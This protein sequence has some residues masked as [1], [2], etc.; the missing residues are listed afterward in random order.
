MM[1]HDYVKLRRFH[2]YV[3]VRSPRQ[4]E[5]WLQ[6]GFVR[7]PDARMFAAIAQAFDPFAPRAFY[8]EVWRRLLPHRPLPPSWFANDVMLELSRAA[9]GPVPSLYVLERRIERG[10]LHESP[11]FEAPPL[12]PR[13]ATDH[14]LVVEAV[15]DTELPAPVAGLRLELLIADGEIKSAQTDANG[16]ARVERVQAGR[17]VIRVLDLDGALWQPVEGD[18]SQP[19]SSGHRPRVHVVKQGECLSRIAHLYG[20]ASW[21]KLWNAAEN[22]QLRKRRKSPHVLYP[23]D[24]VTV[25]GVDV[26]EIIRP[27]DATHRLAIAVPPYHLAVILRDFNGLPFTHEPYELWVTGEAAPRVGETDDDGLVRATLPARASH[28][29]VR[30]NRLGMRWLFAVGALDPLDGGEVVV[31]EGEAPV[32]PENS[33]ISGLQARLHALG[34]PAGAATGQ[35]NEQTER[36]LLA[37][38]T[39]ELGAP[40]TKAGTWTSDCDDALTAR[41]GA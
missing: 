30:C 35:W 37:F 1:G 27:T 41:Y 9:R 38:Q 4:L 22:T 3:L 14:Y 15:T 12:P 40:D 23:G 25:P 24:E 18:A 6:R 33:T 10:V 8:T 7:V 5:P 11:R 36:A 34:Y 31:P 32:R 16:I 13:S 39:Q 20:F 21:H 29:E 28:A 2:D 17:V 19:S 26:H